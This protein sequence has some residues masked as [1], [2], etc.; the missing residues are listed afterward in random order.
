MPA[1]PRAGGGCS[2]PGV[3]RKR[4]RE[5]DKKGQRGDD[6]GGEEGG[7]AGRRRQDDDARFGLV[8]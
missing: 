2:A 3:Q 1:F 6:D 7:G 8:F 4:N 5:G